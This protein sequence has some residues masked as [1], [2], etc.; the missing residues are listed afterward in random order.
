[1]GSRSELIINR[2]G[3]GNVIFR[4]LF[5]EERVHVLLLLFFTY[6]RPLFIKKIIK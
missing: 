5:V 2:I 3:N 6:V 4:I 1:M